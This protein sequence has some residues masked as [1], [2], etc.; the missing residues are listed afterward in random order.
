MPSISTPR[1]GDDLTVN[2][3]GASESEDAASLIGTFGIYASASE[4]G[5][6]TINNDGHI[7]GTDGEAIYAQAFDLV[8][9]N[10]HSY[11]SVV[12]AD[13]GGYFYDD[14]QV[15]VDNQGGL[16]A[17]LSGFNAGLIF[18]YIHGA[19]PASGYAVD[20]NNTEGGIVAGY[21][22]GIYAYDIGSGGGAAK[23]LRIDNSASYDSGLDSRRADRRRHR[24][25][26]QCLDARRQPHHRQQLHQGRID[27]PDVDRPSGR[28]VRER[29]PAP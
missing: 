26:H 25:R 18:S 14:N 20:V 6:L 24:R 8:T 16:T 22:R 27:R 28:I 23:D 10:N 19:A 1:S 3:N 29:R 5:S 17:S 12:G 9:V 7:Q 15:I 2:I 21:Y 11:A 13:N 4:G